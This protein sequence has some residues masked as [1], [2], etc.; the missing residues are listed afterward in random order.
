MLRAASCGLSVLEVWSVKGSYQLLIVGAGP[1]GYVAAIRASQLGMRVGLVEKRDSLGGTCLNIGCI[2]SKALLDSSELFARVRDSANIHGV[3]CTEVSLDLKAMMKRKDRVVKRLTSG[4]SLLMSANKVEVFHGTGRLDGAQ[5]VLVSAKKGNEKKL[6]AEK[7]ILATGSVSQELAFLPFDGKIIV[8]SEQALSFNEVPKK[9]LI[10]GAGAIGLELGSVWSR[11]GSSVE[12]I[13]IMPTILPG[14]DRQLSKKLEKELMT[15]GMKFHLESRVEEGSVKGEKASL[16]VLDK[17]GEERTFSADKVLVAVGR[18][19]YLEGLNI[20]SID[21]QYMEDGTHLKVDEA[22]QTS[23]MGVHAIGDLVNG[24]M[25]AHK[26]EEEGIACVESMAGRAGHVNYNVIPGIVYTWP[27]AASVGYTEDELVARKIPYNRGY[28]PFSANGR[29]LAMNEN[30]GFVKIV[31]DKESDRV[32]GAHIL[33][34][35]ASDLIPEIVA[36]MEFSG[37]AEDIART[38]HPHPTLSEA[39]R[40]AAL[41]ADGRMIHSVN[42]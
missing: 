29:A 6:S 19:P 42:R 21:V 30:A 3:V 26:A 13:E 9:L 2:P 27:E 40:E 39:V 22:F 18:K 32:L 11:L 7:I 1:G 31:S 34:P 15:Q 37:S 8:S 10:I 35:W 20:E 24:P 23:T 33:G 17:N 16:K 38:V 14:W 12:F 5:K 4:V 36:V 41:G 25:L 28:F